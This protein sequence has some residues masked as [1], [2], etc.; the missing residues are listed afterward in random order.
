MHPTLDRVHWETLASFAG[1]LAGIASRRMKLH[2]R[3]VANRAVGTD[4]A[5]ATP[6][7]A[8]FTWPRLGFSTNSRSSTSSEL[9]VQ[10]VDE[11]VVSRAF[12]ALRNQL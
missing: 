8:F 1:M 9:G 5:I 2:R 3:L 7:L 12:Q 11:R 10:V 6:S 4:L